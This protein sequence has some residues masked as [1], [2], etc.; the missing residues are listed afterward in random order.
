MTPLILSSPR[1]QRPPSSDQ[2]ARCAITAPM[3]ADSRNL[4]GML[5][6]NLESSAR[7]SVP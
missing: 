5:V 3:V 6:S 1:S 4:P 2:N 7:P